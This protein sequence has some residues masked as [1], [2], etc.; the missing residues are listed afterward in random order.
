MTVSHLRRLESSAASLQKP[1]TSQTEIGSRDQPHHGQAIREGLEYCHI[2][3]IMVAITLTGHNKHGSTSR[4]T[5]PVICC[6][7]E[8]HN[9]QM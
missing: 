7:A 1:H 9:R 8:K 6:R 2:S 3:I 4:V 5:P